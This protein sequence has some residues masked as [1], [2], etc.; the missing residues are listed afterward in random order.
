V[1]WRQ[2]AKEDSEGAVQGGLQR[3]QSEP[4]VKGEVLGGG[5]LEGGGVKVSTWLREKAEGI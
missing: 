4:E 5:E 2:L 1:R 3:I